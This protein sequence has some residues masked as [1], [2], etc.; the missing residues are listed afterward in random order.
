[1]SGI[2]SGS[3]HA[4]TQRARKHN[5]TTVPQ[6]AALFVHINDI[7]FTR[8]W[9]PRRVTRPKRRDHSVS[10]L[11]ALNLVQFSSATQTYHNGNFTDPGL[12]CAFQNPH[13]FHTS[14]SALV[15]ELVCEV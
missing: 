12:N 15:A 1:M 5:G 11:F 9:G 6:V 14:K 7:A 3:R 13:Q 10:V 8:F 4:L 2:P